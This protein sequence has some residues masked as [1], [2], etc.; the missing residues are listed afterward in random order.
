MLVRELKKGYSVV[1]NGATTML[2]G[3]VRFHSTHGADKMIRVCRVESHTLSPLVRFGLFN[4]ERE[5]F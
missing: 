5:I 4:V 1:V 3:K 2:E